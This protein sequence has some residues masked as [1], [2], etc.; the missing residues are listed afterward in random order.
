VVSVGFGRLLSRWKWKV[1]KPAW[2]VVAVNLLASGSD[3]LSHVSRG[4][5]LGS[6]PKT[7]TR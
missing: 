7:S 5:G 2:C 6:V 4:L 3:L 1:A